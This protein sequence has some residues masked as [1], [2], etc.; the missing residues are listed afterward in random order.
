MASVSYFLIIFD[1]NANQFIRFFN[2]TLES[3][4]IQ[5]LD[6]KNKPYVNFYFYQIVPLRVFG[7]TCNMS[8]K[9][10]NYVVQYVCNTFVNLER[11]E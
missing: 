7:G 8:L 9:Y 1:K 5:Q 4:S 3:M 11:V 6:I 10:L 2:D